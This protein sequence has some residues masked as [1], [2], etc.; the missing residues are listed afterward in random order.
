MSYTSPMIPPL[1]I[2][3]DFDETF[4]EDPGLWVLF[5]RSAQARGHMVSFVT[6]RQPGPSNDDIE[7][8]SAMLNV[9]IIYT[10]FKAKRAFAKSQGHSFDIWIDDKPEAIIEDHKR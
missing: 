9:P 4:T 5:I 6:W 2:A 7:V 1:R 8:Q 10:S 3:M